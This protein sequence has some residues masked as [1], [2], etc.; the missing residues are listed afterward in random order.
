MKRFAWFICICAVAACMTGCAALDSTFDHMP[1]L[2]DEEARIITEYATG[3][4]IQNG[5]ETSRL[6]SDQEIMEA[7]RREAIRL[8]NLEALKASLANAKKEEEEKKKG[9]KSGDG[10]G[11]EEMQMPFAGIAPFCGLND[12]S[13]D[14]VG[15]SIADSYPEEES[16]D[17]FFAM[18]AA[19]GT[20]L[21]ILRFKVTN[22]TSEDRELDMFAKNV[23]FKVAL[24]GEGFKNVLSTMLLDDLSL[25]KDMI[26]AGQSKEL[27]LIREIT[28][29]EAGSLNGIELQLKSGSEEATTSL[30]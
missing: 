5:E 9:G 17:M 24:N 16:D 23:M 8:A 4:V 20:K 2:T 1:T 10:E 12:F 28:L 25:Y 7:D 13:I 19:E 14:Y 29:A 18:D 27:V 22:L 15:H 26:P 21:L 6:A 11:E 3:L 30:E